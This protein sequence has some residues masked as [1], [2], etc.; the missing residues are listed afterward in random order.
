ME[1]GLLAHLVTL[2]ERGDGGG[3]GF[4]I[5]RLGVGVDRRGVKA[6]PSTRDLQVRLVAL[7]LSSHTGELHVHLQEMT[8]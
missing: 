8:L 3:N 2:E 4:D 5:K 6:Q 7:E 1:Y